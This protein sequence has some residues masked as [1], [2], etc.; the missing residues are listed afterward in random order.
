MTDPNAR[1]LKVFEEH[2]QLDVC[3]FSPT[4]VCCI[5]QY[6]GFYSQR[7]E[8]NEDAMRTEPS[9]PWMRPELAESVA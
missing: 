8:V 2:T 4:I 3:I 7:E 6:A 1:W 5:Q 9:E